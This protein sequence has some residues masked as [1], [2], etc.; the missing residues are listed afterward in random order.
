[1]KTFVNYDQQFPIVKFDPDMPTED[2]EWLVLGLF[3]KSKINMIS[4]Y[5][6]SGKTRFLNYLLAGMNNGYVC[7]LP[8]KSLGKVLYLAGEEAISVVNSRLVQYAKVQG[9]DLGQIDIDF[10]AAPGLRLNEERY[11]KWFEQKLPEYDTLVIDPLRRVHSANENDNSE[12]AQLNNYVRRWSNNLGLSIII[13]HHTPKPN[14]M[15]DMNRMENWIRGAGDI[16]AI[17]DM[18]CF[19][20]K[21]PGKI[22]VRRDGRF[23]PG[24][25]LTFTDLGGDPDQGFK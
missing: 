1:M 4:G 24:S 13:I 3:Q 10:M 23:V 9:G 25:P 15:A 17:V 6:K 12:M 21:A 5:V 7:G 16:A 8:T 20:E 2:V 18:A 19:I 14:E 22:T 11:Q